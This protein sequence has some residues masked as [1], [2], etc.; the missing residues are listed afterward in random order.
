MVHVLLDQNDLTLS[1]LTLIF[2]YCLF[3]VSVGQRA[4]I[5]GRP[6]SWLQSN[7]FRYQ[8]GITSRHQGKFQSHWNQQYSVLLTHG[9]CNLFFQMW[10]LIANYFASYR[11]LLYQSYEKL[12]SVSERPI[13]WKKK[14]HRLHQEIWEKKDETSNFFPQANHQSS[15]GTGWYFFCVFYFQGPEMLDQFRRSYSS[16]DVNQVQITELNDVSK[17]SENWPLFTGNRPSK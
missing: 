3:C 7:D 10:L 9:V 11:H 4:R 15:L 2:R 17:C 13:L 14:L 1:H 16:S 12:I 8:F 5:F 6:D